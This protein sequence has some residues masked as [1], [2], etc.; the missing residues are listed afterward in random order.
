MHATLAFSNMGRQEG[1]GASSARHENDVYTL[2]LT[3]KLIN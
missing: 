1:K 2:L 3:Y